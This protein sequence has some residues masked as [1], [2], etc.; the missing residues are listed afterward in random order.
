MQVKNSVSKKD[1]S[2]TRRSLLPSLEIKPCGARYRSGNNCSGHN[3]N[4]A[5]C[6]LRS[7]L[8]RVASTFGIV[9]DAEACLPQAQD[10]R[11]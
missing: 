8:L 7:S 1:P 6:L 4:A 10:C 2:K 5:T 3:V 11:S 9:F